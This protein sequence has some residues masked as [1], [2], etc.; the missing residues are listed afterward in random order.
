MGLFDL[1]K[2]QFIDVIQWNDSGNTT[3]VYKFPDND[4]EIKMGAQLIVRES[5]VAIFLNEGVMAD[6]YMPGRYELTTQ[7]M[8]ILTTLN[9]WKYGFNSP[10]KCDVYFVS[11]RQFTNQKWGTAN[12]VM[13]RDSE[14]GMIRMRAY[15]SYSFRV[16]DAATFFKEIAGTQV[17][18]DTE[19]I[20][21]LLKGIVLSSFT[22]MIAESKIAAIDMAQSYNELGALS[23]NQLTER[24][25]HM[26]LKATNMIIEN[27]SLPP[28]VEAALDKRTT[29]GVLGDMGKYAQYQTAEA[30]RDAAKNPGGLAGLGASIGVGAGVGNMM[31]QAMQNMN[32]PEEKQVVPNSKCTECGAGIKEGAKFCP[33]CGSK[34]MT[35]KTCSCGAKLHTNA[36]FCPE[37]GAKQNA[38]KICACGAKL[39]EGAKFCPECGAKA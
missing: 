22:D 4:N 10:F 12:P 28:E 26:G 32:K 30:I 8:P 35:E 34:Q 19:H 18:F 23:T 37:C 1:F 17:E 14:F 15:G 16:E 27:I 11:T 21:G 13:M 7:N 2:G 33:E 36:K 20:T 31:G 38:E 39:K 5:Q 25:S 9:S 6:V 24:F 29:M 3:I